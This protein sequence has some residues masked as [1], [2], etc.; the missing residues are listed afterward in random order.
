MKI[1]F[2]GATAIALLAAI[3]LTGCQKESNGGGPVSSPPP[4]VNP[5]TPVQ[6]APVLIGWE[7]LKNDVPYLDHTTDGDV[8]YVRYSQGFTINGF[9]FVCGGRMYD[10]FTEGGYAPE[11]YQ[12]DPTTRDWDEKVGFQ[13]PNPAVLALAINFVIGDNVYMVGT[14]KKT[15]RYNQPTDRWSTVASYPGTNDSALC[16]FAVNGLGYVGMGCSKTGNTSNDW[17]QYDPA[18]NHWYAM[19][20]FPGNS[21]MSAACFTVDGKGYLVGGKHVAS[22]TTGLGT[23]VWQYTPGASGVNG[24]WTKMKD[25]PGSARYWTNGAAATIGGVDVGLLIGG[26][27]SGGLGVGD[28][29]EYFPASDSWA[30]LPNIP[31]TRVG[32]GVFVLGKSLFVASYYVDVMG[33]SN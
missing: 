31:R 13:G 6:L 29:W 8:T 7:A 4:K 16:G 11:L 15:Y 17:W 26:V 21:R 10:G 22:G 27:V 12:Y 2:P 20:T 25:F 14:D 33:W 28:A 9:G 32:P 19:N 3:L 23:T 18:T 1:T 30:Q 24:S 5:P